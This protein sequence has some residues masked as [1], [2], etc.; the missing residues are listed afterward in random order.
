MIAF[1]TGATGFVGREVVKALYS[2]GIDVRC[3]IRTPARER[4]LRD[5]PVEV[6]Y[7]SIQDPAALRAAFYNIDVVVHLVAVIRESG[8]AT[9]EAIN[10][11]GTE[12][13]VEVAQNEG[14]SHFI[15]Q[16]ALGTADD[17]RFPYLRSKWQGEQAVINSGLPYTIL[18]PSIL[19][20]E[21]DEFTN[22][23]AGLVK[24]FP[25]VP[26]VGS[27]KIKL[28]PLAVDDMAR[29]IASA[30]GREDLMGRVIEIGGPDHLSYNEINDIIDRT[31]RSWRLKLHI[32]EPLMRLLVRVMEATLPRPPAT[33]HQL[34]M[35]GVPNVAELNTLEQTF[36]FRPKPVQGNIEYIKAIS[37]WAGLKMTLGFES[38]SIREKS[39]PGD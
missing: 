13:L 35:L 21:E 19:F 20:G 3:L 32:P 38:N 36:G 39:K 22:K 14:T 28:Q 6:H 4:I 31:Y 15:H 16:S 24:A 10:K 9:F 27:G 30:A 11:N 1:V 12:N 7:G 8:D 18:R 25:I 23:L 29:C 33:T 5:Y 2:R 34:G 26:V 17:P 37:R